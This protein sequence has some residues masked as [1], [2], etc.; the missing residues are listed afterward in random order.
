M[1]IE[2]THRIDA[3]REQ[4]FDLLTNPLLLQKTIP[5][6]EKMEKTGDN[7]YAARLSVGVGPI[8]GI[9]N[10]TVN[11]TELRR[12]EHY[13]LTMDGKGQPGF[14]KGSGSLHFVDE[15]GATVVNFTGDISVGGLI[16]SVGQRM[17]QSVGKMMAERFFVALENEA[18][19][20]QKAS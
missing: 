12:P 11:L 6:C 14:V 20:Q 1:K 19:A 9:F 2:G 7:Q 18:K 15:N 3:S 13:A 17:I 4:I 16:A 10:A 8:K 5:G